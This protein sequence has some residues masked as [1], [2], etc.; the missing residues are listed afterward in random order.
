MVVKIRINK[1]QLDMRLDNEAVEF[2]GDT[3]IYFPETTGYK[4]HYDIFTSKANGFHKPEDVLP[5]SILSIPHKI[6]VGNND[7]ETY[8]FLNA[9]INVW[10]SRAYEHFR[11]Q[12]IERGGIEVTALER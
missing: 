6:S 10:Y 1:K 2:E 8:V 4:P 11:D 7:E 5:E 3:L 9:N 12:F